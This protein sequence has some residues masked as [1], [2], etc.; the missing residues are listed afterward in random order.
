M[1][2]YSIYSLFLQDIVTSLLLLYFFLVL[3][4]LSLLF[5]HKPN[6]YHI[7]SLWCIHECHLVWTQQLCIHRIWAL[8]NWCWSLTIW[9][10][11]SSVSENTAKYKYPVQY[12]PLISTYKKEQILIMQNSSETIPKHAENSFNGKFCSCLRKLESFIFKVP[13]YPHSKAYQESNWEAAFPT[14]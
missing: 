3:H 4:L 11:D 5:V 6:F 10:S 12:F 13:S 1:K 2:T 14:R 9:N 7:T 8:K